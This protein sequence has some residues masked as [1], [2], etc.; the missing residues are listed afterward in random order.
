MSN[1]KKGQ[2]K[3]LLCRKELE[4][5][6]WIIIFKSI[7]TRWGSYDMADLFDVCAVKPFRTFDE[8]STNVVEDKRWLFVSVKNY[9]TF[10]NLPQHQEEIKNFKN[11]YGLAGMEFQ[12]WLWRR[13][14]L[15]GR[16]ANKI[17]SK[18]EWKKI[19]I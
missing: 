11:L 10:K 8:G 19:T 13:A 6:G 14:K 12:L 17:W 3:E 15:Q 7:R 1:V 16:G 5:E 2:S 4:K 9:T 18:A